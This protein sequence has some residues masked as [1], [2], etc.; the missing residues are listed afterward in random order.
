MI[1]SLQKVQKQWEKQR[2]ELLEQWAEARVLWEDERSFLI[3]ERNAVMIEYKNIAVEKAKLQKELST[4]L[5]EF[6]A[7]P[8]LGPAS[9]METKDVATGNDDQGNSATIP[10]VPG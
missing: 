3:D 5:E 6:I 2:T 9:S 1:T 4:V 10:V 7:R 8:P